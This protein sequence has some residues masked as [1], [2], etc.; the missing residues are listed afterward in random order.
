[1]KTAAIALSALLALPGCLSTADVDRD[2]AWTACRGETDAAA[3]QTCI[4]DEM[5]DAA[6]ERREYTREWEAETAA[7]ERTAGELD[8]RGVPEDERSTGPV[9]DPH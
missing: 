6:A 9:R 4:E 7:R 5:A 8:A 3:R 1:M 2:R